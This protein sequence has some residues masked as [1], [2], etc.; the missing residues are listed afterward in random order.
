MSNSTDTFWDVDGVSLQTLAWNIVTLGG[1]RLAPPTL[2]GSNLIIPSAPG[3]RWMPKVVDSRTITLGMWVIGANEDGTAPT[4]GTAQKFDANFR[5][6]R[7][8]L[9]TPN[10]EITLT[11]RFYVDGVLKTA[12]A[13]AQYAGGLAP[14]MNG[15]GRAVFTVD[16]FLSDPY[17][18]GPETT[19]T[20]ANG[21]QTVTIS[22]DD[23]TRAIKLTAH[24]SRKYP[25]VR[26]NTLNVDVEYHADL[27]ASDTVLM[28]VKNYTSVTT[29]SGTPQFSSVGSIRHTGNP[30]WFLLQPGDN[31]V[32]VSSSTGTGTVTMVYQEVWL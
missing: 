28:D 10:R 24:G 8:L 27:S 17:F 18:Y 5:K 21:S 4:G 6:L 3:S 26:N 15:R 29:P 11:K 31:T 20:L 30:F 7:Q 19:K 9:W 23:T 14:T 1:D 13:K 22:G 2:R 25:K 32:V 16:L 12:V